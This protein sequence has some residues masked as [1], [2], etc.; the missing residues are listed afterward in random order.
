MDSG[1]ARRTVSEGCVVGCRNGACAGPVIGA[2]V[3]VGAVAVAVAG[4]GAG[5]AGSGTG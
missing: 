5:L 3:G 2:G 4:A 1:P